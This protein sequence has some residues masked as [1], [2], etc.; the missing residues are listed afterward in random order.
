M[1]AL[2]TWTVYG[3]WLPGPARGWV[4]APTRGERPAVGVEARG[5]VPEPD[6]AIS[7]LRGGSLKWPAVRLTPMQQRH[8]VEDLRRVAHLR[9]FTPRLAVIAEDHVH[10]LLEVDDARYTPRLVQLIKGALSRKLTVMAG[11]EAATAT[12]G[13]TLPHHKWWTRQYAFQ[14]V[15]DSEELVAIESL[16][17]AH[18]SAGALIE[19]RWDDPDEPA[20]DEGEG[21]QG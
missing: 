16:L 4:D 10:V 3:T 20:K 18:A 6:P 2:L 1:I 15:R 13:A 7:A 8:I 11:D 5:L 9:H 14:A 19:D 21:R 17:R 12:T